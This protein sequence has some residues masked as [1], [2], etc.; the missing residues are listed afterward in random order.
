MMTDHDEW[1]VVFFVDE[2]EDSFTKQQR[3]QK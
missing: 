2:E 1:V 3:N